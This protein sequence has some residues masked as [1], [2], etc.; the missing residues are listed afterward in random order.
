MKMLLYGRYFEAQ[1][2]AANETMGG[3][4]SRKLLDEEIGKFPY[5]RRKHFK[6]NVFYYALPNHVSVP[7]P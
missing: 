7:K 4:Y 5:S 6:V 3:N 1:I 2:M